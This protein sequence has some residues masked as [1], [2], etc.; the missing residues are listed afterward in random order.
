M[1]MANWS[2]A[3]ATNPTSTIFL[4]AQWQMVLLIFHGKQ[5]TAPVVTGLALERVAQLLAITIAMAVAILPGTLRTSL[6]D[7]HKKRWQKQ[8]AL[9]YLCVLPKSSHCI[10]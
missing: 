4:L 2:K 8:V 6:A 9:V 7:V 5:P 3:V 10:L 1:N